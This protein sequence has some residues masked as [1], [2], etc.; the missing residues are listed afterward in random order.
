MI[1][2]GFLA[3]FGGCFGA[4]AAAIVI[5]VAVA[6]CTVA[7]ETPEP[8][9]TPTP[10]IIVVTPTPGPTPTPRTIVVTP[11]PTP[12]PTLVPKALARSMREAHLWVMVYTDRVHVY[13]PFSSDFRTSL[14]SVRV[15]LYGEDGVFGLYAGRVSVLPLQRLYSQE[16][17]TRLPLTEGSHPNPVIRVEADVRGAAGFSLNSMTCHPQPLHRIP[18]RFGCEP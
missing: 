3:T 8:T 6:L 9:P 10:R 17:T 5:G 18:L 1:T 16:E 13:G 15:T 7:T 4:L 11:S 12:A 2:K 14:A